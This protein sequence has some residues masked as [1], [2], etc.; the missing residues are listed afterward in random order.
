[1]VTD[2]T[3]MWLDG[4]WLFKTVWPTVLSCHGLVQGQDF[5]IKMKLDG[6]AKKL[7]LPMPAS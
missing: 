3:I 7:W 2:M 5:L 4:F 1:M 6:H